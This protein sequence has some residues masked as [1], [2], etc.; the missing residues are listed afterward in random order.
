MNEQKNIDHVKQVYD[1]FTKGDIAGLL[2]QL[3]D[4]ISWE[5][6][7]A[8]KIPYAGRFKGRAAMTKFFEGVGKTAEFSR[9]EPRDYI[10]Q[11]DRVIVLGHYAGKGKATSR[12]FATD[13]AMIFTVRNGKVTDFKEYFDTANLGSAFS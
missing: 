12:P 1:L 3:A 7:G 13:W 2:N 11:G 10:A 8:P 4:D 9:F 5:T 6:P